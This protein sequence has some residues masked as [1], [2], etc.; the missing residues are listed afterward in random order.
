MVLEDKDATGLEMR[1]RNLRNITKD[2]VFSKFE[3]PRGQ[4]TTSQNSDSMLYRA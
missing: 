2:K 3:L 4:D 1:Q